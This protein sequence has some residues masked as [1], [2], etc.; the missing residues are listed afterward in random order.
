MTTFLTFISIIA[1]FIL[2]KFIYETYLTNKKRKDWYKYKNSNP[3]SSFSIERNKGHDFSTI[4]KSREQDKKE[5]LLRMAVNMGCSPS[6]VKECFIKGLI[7]QH[8]TAAQVLETIEMCS[9]KK[10]EE[11]R[12]FS[13][14]PADTSASYMEEWTNEYFENK[15]YADRKRTIDEAAK[16]L[17]TENPELSRIVELKDESQLYNFFDNNPDLMDSMLEDLV[18]AKKPAEKFLR[19]ARKKVFDEN[20]YTGAIQLINK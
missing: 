18:L 17:M 2:G 5:S 16:D 19:K 12:V 20:D 8:L 10:Y 9:Q 1:L 3:E 14:D 6:Q 15:G 11:S 7:N 13:I 4:S